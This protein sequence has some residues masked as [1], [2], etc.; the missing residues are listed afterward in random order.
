MAGPVKTFFGIASQDDLDSLR[1]KIEKLSSFITGTK[2]KFPTYDNKFAVLEETLNKIKTTDDLKELKNRFN[3]IVED[4]DKFM[5]ESKE[6]KEYV[7]PILDKH[8]EQI[9]NL[10]DHTS[11]LTNKIESF[12]SSTDITD[13]QLGN[14]AEYTQQIADAHE[15]LNA[16]FIAAAVAIVICVSAILI[17]Q[18]TKSQSS[19]NK[20]DLNNSFII[21]NENPRSNLVAINES[22][23]TQKKEKA[24]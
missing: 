2:E 23:T 11:M 17:Y 9:K 1:Y 7:Q 5:G 14:V 12:K 4:L 16:A 15:Q 21:T 10:K 13:D 3:S 6:W 24:A 8:T 18:Y 22:S 20:N 19:T